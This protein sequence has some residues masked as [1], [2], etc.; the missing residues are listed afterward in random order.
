MDKVML[1]NIITEAIYLLEKG[2]VE[3]ATRLLKETND[4]INASYELRYKRSK[5]R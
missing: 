4:S 3:E 1:E 5:A 2:K